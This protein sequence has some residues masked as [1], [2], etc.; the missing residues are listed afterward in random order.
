MVFRNIVM[1][2]I[3]EK[4][5]WIFILN[6]YCCWP[7]RWCEYMYIFWN[8]ISFTHKTYIICSL[9]PVGYLLHT[10]KAKNLFQHP[11][12]AK[13]LLLLR[14]SYYIDLV[15]CD[16][17][18]LIGQFPNQCGVD[19]GLLLSAARFSECLCYRTLLYMC[20]DVC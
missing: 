14:R 9:H 8:S 13:L 7:D 15:G 10:Y 2:F 6:K 17:L 16:V 19:Y 12:H 4:H 20:V 3:L 11:V 18:R 5:D 1:Q